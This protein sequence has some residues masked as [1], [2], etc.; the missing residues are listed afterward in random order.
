MSLRKHGARLLT[1]LL[2]WGVP[3]G[4]AGAQDDGSVSAAVAG[5]ALGL[6][7][8]AIL[9]VAGSII[10]CT[11]T[12][13]GAGCIWGHALGAGALGLVSGALMG[14]ADADRVGSAAG[15]A[16]IG[17]LAGSAAGLILKPI[18]QR[19][20]WHDVFTV[21]LVGGAIGASPEGAALGFGA[22]AVAGV[23]LWRVIPG[24]T[25]PDALGAA[26]AGLALGGVGG[27]IVRG[28]ERDSPDVVFPV[29]IPLA[30]IRF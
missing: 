23:L 18:A 22:G 24:G 27:W 2:L 15:S 7:S 11:Q 29:A 17:F 21:G 3:S 20:G 1:G 5:G 30:R 13:D 25:F 12:Y 14:A 6:F 9:G 19:V 8:G 28:L 4:L 10:P 26:L 16:G